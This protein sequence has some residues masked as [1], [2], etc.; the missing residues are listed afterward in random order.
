MP[1]GAHFDTTRGIA[2]T[3]RRPGGTTDN[4]PAVHC[5]VRISPHRCRVP[6]GRL[7]SRG[8]ERR[9]QS[10]RRDFTHLSRAS[11]PAM[12]RWVMLGRPSGTKTPTTLRHLLALLLVA[13]SL[14]ALNAAPSRAQDGPPLETPQPAGPED[15]PLPRLEDMQ[16]PTAAQLLHEP[17]LDWV[18][19]KTEDVIVVEPVYPRP[20]T[21]AQMQKTIDAHNEKLKNTATAE[22]EQWRA[23]RDKLNYLRLTLPGDQEQPEYQLHIRFI[24]EIIHHEDLMLR[25]VNESLDNRDLRGA[26]ELIMRIDRRY[27]GWP[28]VE[29]ARNRLIFLEAE[30][31]GES[32]DWE[33]AFVFLEDLHRREPNFP[34]LSL[35]LG[36]AAGRLIAAAAEADD[37]REARHFLNRLVQRQSEHAVARKWQSE[38]LTRAERLLQQAQQASAA[39]RYDE[40]V[41]LADKAA[42]VWPTA[43]GL[44]NIH[45]RV[46]KRFQR[47]DVGVVRLAG[48]PTA[49][50]FPAGADQRHAHL[51]RLPLFEID[52]AGESARYRSRFFE[53]WEPTDLGRRVVFTL[54][55]SVS[56]WESQSP[57]TAGPIVEALQARLN[58]LGPDYD[59]RLATHLDAIHIISPF[60]FEIGFAQVPLRVEPLF[61]F[62]VALAHD[63]PGSAEPE[64][65]SASLP[66]SL[67]SQRFRLQERS[68]RHLSYRR[69]VPEPD[70]LTQYHVAEVV[71]HK[72]DDY[73]QSVQGLFRGE[74]ALLPRID[75][76]DVHPLRRDGRFFIQQYGLPDTHILQFH[77]ASPALQHRELRRALAYA[78]DREHILRRMLLPQGSEADN[79]MERA[80][81]QTWG[82]I[83]TA[84]WPQ[85]NKG[86]DALVE[87]HPHDATLAASLAIAARKQLGGRLPML[88]M[89]CPPD[90]E[91]RGVAGELVAQWKKI[92]LAVQL[93][94]DDDPEAGWDI[95]YRTV[96][97]ADPQAHLWPLLTL[98]ST[99]RVDALAYLPDWLRQE[100]IDL[101]QARDWNT[102]ESLLR[103][104]HRYLHAE[105]QYVP[106]WEVDEFLALRK[107]V[108]GLPERP[109]HP[110]HN[111]ER[112]VADPWY[113]RDAP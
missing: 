69:S 85:Q 68:E 100:L 4:S 2:R 94:P 6:E 39:D 103:D 12:N 66:D 24:R 76:R 43:A 35:R 49:Y 10:S 1:H 55:R 17:P 5:W 82:R 79:Q 29:E 38:L 99:T 107:N 81:Q 71:E 21:L 63:S 91:T 14:L 31:R 37:Y 58:P 19:L 15:P 102:A 34:D 64:T 30:K 97:M 8:S 84:A 48:E 87:P 74:V 40:A 105:V 13:L 72:Y 98:Q 27:P 25:R 50:P 90:P 9:I 28:G 56:P 88:K 41:T 106:L 109:L 112:W 111:I 26:F 46:A 101:E 110:Y 96:R 23:E 54:R 20:G 45:Q 57:L 67:L 104:L 89:V 33:Q 59:A 70:G 78:I 7:K 108:H 36:E 52:A 42:R 77:P 44:Q 80:E 47:L 32:G 3:I 75:R 86:Y 61:A 95:L 113:P 51:T 83:T 53:E 65:E 62:A 18:V 22:V 93:V 11:L 73:E 16:T 60:E 92:G